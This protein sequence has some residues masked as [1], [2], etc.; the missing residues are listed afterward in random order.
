VHYIA[1]SR[2]GLGPTRSRAAPRRPVELGPVLDFPGW[3]FE[4][5]GK[6]ASEKTLK[7]ELVS[8]F[9]HSLLDV[10]RCGWTPGQGVLVEALCRAL[11][12][13]KMDGLIHNDSAAE[14]FILWGASIT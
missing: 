10:F 1:K 9:A 3:F 13:E 5:V 14:F 2:T 6:N 4:K 7:W 12:K 8:R 11:V